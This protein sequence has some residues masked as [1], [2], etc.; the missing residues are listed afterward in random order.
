MCHQNIQ[1]HLNEL[2]THL[3]GRPISPAFA[4]RFRFLW[5]SLDS[6]VDFSGRS[7]GAPYYVT[8]MGV[9]L[10]DDPRLF[11]DAHLKLANT[12]AIPRS[13]LKDF[14][15][16]SKLDNLKHRIDAAILFFGDYETVIDAIR[17]RSSEILGSGDYELLIYCGVVTGACGDVKAIEFFDEAECVA[18]NPT[19]A[20]AAAHRSA[21]FEI[22]KLSA[23]NKALQR[24]NI[25]GERYVCSNNFRQILDQALMYNL[26]ALGYL[27][28]G[29]PRSAEFMVKACE[30][31]ESSSVCRED[32]DLDT[33]S[34][35]G[36]YRSQIA[37]NQAQLRVASSKPLDALKILKDNI[38]FIYEESYEYFPEA[39][40]EYCYVMY[41]NEEYDAVLD[42]GPDAFWRF[43]QIGSLSAMKSVREIMA[44]CH[45]KLGSEGK[46]ERV[47]EVFERDPLGLEGIYGL[48]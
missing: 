40:A 3:S 18:H 44:A 8:D 21:A 19:N 45:F 43:Q 29:D 22:K 7:V 24:L 42:I 39:L 38:R 28:L 2:N 26:M 16:K 32:F 34:M 5:D 35:A 6:G 15:H 10:F 23:S 47:V 36:R 30:C 4:E 14:I 46:A 13:A 12:E 33:W 31:L 17:E 11:Y 9:R 48:I 1:D 41:L 27:K 20:Y 25:A 37:I